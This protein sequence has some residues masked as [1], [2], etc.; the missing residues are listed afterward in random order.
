ML[1]ANHTSLRTRLAAWLWL[2]CLQF[3]LAEAVSTLGFAGRYSYRLS[4]ISDLGAVH[5]TPAL[6]SR[7]HLLMD[8]SFFL[9][10]ILIAGGA[11]LLP[12]RYSPGWTGRVSRGLLLLAAFGVYDVAVAPEDVNINKHIFGAGLNFFAGALAMLFWSIAL[13]LYEHGHRRKRGPSPGRSRQAW[14]A[15]AAALVAGTGVRLLY[16]PAGPLN[17]FL[18]AGTVERLAAYPLPL[19]LAWMGWTV[20]RSGRGY[21]QRAV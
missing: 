10:A 16:H 2:G 7:W 19:W 20:L 12:L 13:A 9:Q 11:L 17:G 6:C 21:R 1:L 5:C 8:G 18:G 15:F 14:V 4:Y 3:F